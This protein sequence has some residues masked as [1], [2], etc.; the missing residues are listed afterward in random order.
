MATF[1]LSPTPIYKGWDANGIPLAGGQLFTYQAGT[2]TKLAAYLDSTGTVAT[3]PIRLNARGETP[4]WIPPNVAYKYVLASATDTDPPGAP[5]QT[6]DNVVNS[7]LLTLY[8][9]VD[10]GIVNAYVLNFSAQ[11]TSYT[12]GIAIYW[13]PSHTNTGP[14]TIN[15]N[16][17][18]VTAIVNQDGTPL[19]ANQ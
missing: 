4:L 10:T 1:T 18:G 14:S 2:T 8:G 12:D 3:N 5:I 17:I 7:Q 19:G 9:G 16:G 6:T 13:I 11:F 15:I